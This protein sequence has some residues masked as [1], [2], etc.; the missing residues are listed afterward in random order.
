MNFRMLRREA[1]RELGERAGLNWR[2]SVALQAF[3]KG[4]ALLTQVPLLPGPS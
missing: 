2:G 1:A 3:F 4:G